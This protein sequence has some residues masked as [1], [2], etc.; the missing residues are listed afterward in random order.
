ME[1]YSRDAKLAFLQ[2]QVTALQ[3]T[4]GSVSIA[5]HLP[6]NFI[7]NPA[8]PSDTTRFAVME[9]RIETLS[10]Q[11]STPSV[12]RRTRQDRHPKWER[13]ARQYNNNN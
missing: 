1:F 12:A 9:A 2:E 5:S 4:N 8:A 11:Q 13:D 10:K 7:N 6:V 3:A